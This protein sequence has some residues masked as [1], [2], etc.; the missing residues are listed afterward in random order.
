M[1]LHNVLYA[2]S[3]TGLDKCLPIPLW[4]FWCG[5]QL[6]RGDCSDCLCGVGPIGWNDKNIV[7]VCSGKRESCPQSSD[8]GQR[9][10]VRSRPIICGSRTAY[11]LTAVRRIAK[12]DS[13][14]A[15]RRW[16]SARIDQRVDKAKREL[17]VRC[18]L[19]SCDHVEWDRLWNRIEV[20]LEALG[21]ARYGEDGEG[22]TGLKFD[23]ER[24]K[25]AHGGVGREIKK[26]LEPSRMRSS[27]ELSADVNVNLAIATVDLRP[28]CNRRT[29]S[30]RCV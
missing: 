20:D 6:L 11:A 25:V 10:L 26:E 15:G 5:Y 1:A 19:R 18:H 16:S 12:I 28:M 3:S 30:K 4:R 13:P 23:Q 21:Y 7:R 9:A 17:T 8:G 14:Q 29:L 24:R 27:R 22:L 2:T